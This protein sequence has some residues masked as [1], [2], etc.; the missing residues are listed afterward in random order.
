MTAQTVVQHHALTDV[1]DH[2]DRSGILV[3]V[4]DTNEDVASEGLGSCQ[5]NHKGKPRADRS[6]S[7]WRDLAWTEE[8]KI[9]KISSG[10]GAPINLD[11]RI[12]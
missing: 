5:L 4:I 12:I 9:A 10:F 6:I 2:L 7:S 8:W 3:W 11:A 1:I